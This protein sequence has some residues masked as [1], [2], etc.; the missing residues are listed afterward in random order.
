[1]NLKQLRYIIEVFRNNLNISFTAQK[2]YTSQPG[3]SKQIHLLEEELGTK[4]FYRNGKHLKKTTDAGK[5]I[6]NNINDILHKIDGIKKIAI[7]YNDEK[8]GCLD[9]ATTQTQKRY[10]QMDVIKKFISQYPEISLKIHTLPDSSIIQNVLENHY[11]FAIF[12]SAPSNSKNNIFVL[13]CFHWKLSIIT[14]KNHPLTQMINFNIHVLSSYKLLTYTK[15]CNGRTSIDQAFNKAGILPKIIFTSMDTS[16]IKNY[17]RMNLGIGI[18]AHLEYD[19][20]LDS[21]LTLIDASH[22]FNLSTTLIAFHKGVFFRSYMYSFI[23]LMAPHLTKD[24]LIDIIEKQDHN[25]QATTLLTN[26]ISI[27]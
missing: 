15:H 25:Q 10:I 7:E 5:K 6:I 19:P 8:K 14:P 24:K 12:A 2:L 17:V 1:M 9:I 26:N 22:L 21:D 18:I 4:I 23:E 27:Y 3:I 11:D 20:N 16:T 13:P